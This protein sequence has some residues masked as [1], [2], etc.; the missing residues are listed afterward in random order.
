MILG[1]PAP[2]FAS[3]LVVAGFGSG[4]LLAL[5]A[6]SGGL[7]W[8]DSIAATGGRGSMA[9]ISAISAM[10]VIAGER[11]FAIG[12]GGLMVALDLHTGRRLWEREV[13]GS[14]TP[15]VAGDWMF[16]VT[17]DQRAAALDTRDG[18]A[19]WVSNLPRY[20]NAKKQRD[21]IAWF[22]PVMAG[23]RLVF[24]GTN[25][26]AIAVDASSGRILGERKLPAAAAVA[27]VLAGGTL[28]LVTSDGSLLAYR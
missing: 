18:V 2:A 6:D 3:G 20:Q 9:D 4:D 12:Q 25:E 26:R 17:L 10:P 24:G 13:A 11:V 7:A 5:R 1:E 19:A 15:W 28:Y 16:I 23:D 14:Q 21:P 27:P 8:S 22:G